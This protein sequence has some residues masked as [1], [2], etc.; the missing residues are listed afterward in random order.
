GRRGRRRGG[1]RGGGGGRGWRRGRPP[2]LLGR[3]TRAACREAS[4]RAAAAP[5]PAPCAP[6][7]PA[8]S[9]SRLLLASG[10]R[11]ARCRPALYSALAL[12]YT[13]PKLRGHRCPRF[14]F[15]ITRSTEED[16]S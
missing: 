5:R 4:P 13:L 9:P 7:R 14:S 1:C 6:C 3:R 15:A 12:W 16:S 2:P 11:A 10:V 8:A